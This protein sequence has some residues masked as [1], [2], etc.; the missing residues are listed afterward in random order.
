[1]NE[2]VM[3]SRRYSLPSL[4]QVRLGFGALKKKQHSTTEDDSANAIDVT[5]DHG[6]MNLLFDL[7][8][9]RSHTRNSSS[10][11][12]NTPLSATES[13]LL[14]CKRII[15]STHPGHCRQLPGQHQLYQIFGNRRVDRLNS[16]IDCDEVYPNLFIGNE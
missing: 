8:G 11:T 4:R 14:H 1:M 12:S 6:M 15:G 10:S 13:K 2:S 16:K 5:G 3:T 7:R 9:R